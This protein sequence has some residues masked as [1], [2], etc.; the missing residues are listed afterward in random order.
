[1]T[2][3]Y[4]CILWWPWRL[5]LADHN[6]NLVSLY[7]FLELGDFPSITFSL[8]LF[9]SHAGSLTS[10][11]SNHFQNRVLTP[12]FW[13]SSLCSSMRRSH[14][15]GLLLLFSPKLCLTLCDPKD[16][17]PKGSSDDGFSQ[18]RI[19][20][21]VAISISREFSWPRDQTPAFCLAA[22]PLPLSRVGSPMYSP[23]YVRWIPKNIYFSF[24]DYAKAFDCLDYNKLWKI[25]KEMEIPDHLT[26]LLRNLYADQETTELDL[27]ERTDSKLEKE[28]VKAVFCHPAYLTYEIWN[29]RLDE[30]QTGIK[31]ES[32]SCSVMSNSLWPHGLYSPWNSPGQ[33]NGVGN[34][35]LLQGIF[36]T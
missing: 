17:S 4:I 5:S 7:L 9:S 34:P 2:C 15:E 28:Y 30:L 10:E 3:T 33:N 1:M 32:E 20:E 29:A 8:P 25:L 14:S 31:T 27:E 23:W 12:V 6:Y 22:N 36:P 24:T 13:F 19:L 21:W 16:C 35:S 26:C 11:A 18:T